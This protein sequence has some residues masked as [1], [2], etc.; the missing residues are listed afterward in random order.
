M[1]WHQ[2]CSWLNNSPFHMIIFALTIF[3][4]CTPGSSHQI[5]F[6]LSQSPPKTCISNSA[7][8]P[9]SW[10]SNAQVSEHVIMLCYHPGLQRFS[11]SPHRGLPIGHHR[12][13]PQQ[14]EALSAVFACGERLLGQRGKER[15]LSRLN[16]ETTL[17]LKYIHPHL[18]HT[19][20]RAGVK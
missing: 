16:K 15:G 6:F 2:P 3:F 5:I 19:V 1:T 12:D 9:L 17:T 14:K 11:P 8:I 18:T 10:E 13:P 7:E 4:F 20:S